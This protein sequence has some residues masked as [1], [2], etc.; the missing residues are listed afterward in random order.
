MGLLPIKDIAE[1]AGVSIDYVIKIYNQLAE[2]AQE[3]QG[4][5]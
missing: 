2:E 4:K 1:I 5:Q 3:Q